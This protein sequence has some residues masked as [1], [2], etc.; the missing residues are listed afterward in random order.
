MV[1]SE[2]AKTPGLCDQRLGDP[3]VAGDLGRP[4]LAATLAAALFGIKNRKPE[5]PQ[6]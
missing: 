5:V 3:R 6:I 2:V 4:M 1:K